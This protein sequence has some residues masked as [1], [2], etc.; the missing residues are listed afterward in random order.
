MRVSMSLSAVCVLWPLFL[1][2]SWQTPLP[3]CGSEGS[4]NAGV[5]PRES[6]ASAALGGGRGPGQFLNLR[7]TFSQGFLALSMVPGK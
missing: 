7:P 3:S 4:S 6:P 2:S 1:E 5:E